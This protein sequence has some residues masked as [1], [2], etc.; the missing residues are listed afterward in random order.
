MNADAMP[1]WER[2][3]RAPTPSFPTW[4]RH[5]PDRLAYVSNESGAYQAYTYDIRSGERRRISDVPI[6]VWDAMPTADGGGVVWFE[7][8]TGDESGR[9]VVA[10]FGG[11]DAETLLPA[12]SPAWQ[13][14]I[15]LGR[16]VIVGAFA[17]RDG[18]AVGAQHPGEGPRRLYRNVE[19]VHIGGSDRAGFN[20]GGL[21]ADERLLCIEHSE[22]G[23]EVRRALRVL[24]AGTGAVVGDQWD[25]EGLGLQAEAWSP[26]AGDPR[27]AIRH[28]RRD[29]ERPAIWDLA[30]NERSDLEIDLPGDVI[31]L[32]WWPDASALLVAHLFEGR[33]ELFR[34]D[35]GDGALARVE[36]PEGTIDDARVRPDGD[37][38]LQVSSGDSAPR[39]L[40]QAGADV[41]T[42]DPRAPTGAPFHSWRFANRS[43]DLVHGFYAAPGG[44]GPFP[45]L[46]YV[47]GGPTGQDAD[48]WDP[49]VQ[50]FVDQGFVVG[51][52]NYRGSTGYGRAWRDFLVGNVG[53]PEEED[54][55]AGLSDLVARGIGDPDRAVIGGWSWGGYVTLLSIGRAPA[56]WRAAVGGVPVGDYAAGYDELSPDLQAYDRYLMGG[57][58]PHDVPELMAE[59]SPIVYAPRVRTPTLVLIGRNDVRC[60]YR[61]AM[62]WVDAVRAHGG[63]VEVYEYDSGHTSYDVDEVVRQMRA[64]LD[65]LAR[66]VVEI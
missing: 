13:A 57:K 25:G 35:L 27:L 17:D 24:D 9:W 44:T 64:I 62:A 51:L 31:P 21:S 7:D 59:R 18:Y 46:M 5:A 56:R 38:W 12:P 47:H 15:A 39:A 26:V 65:F 22:H 11:G 8:V 40:S 2:R 48:R 63:E 58:T 28:E 37:V 14:G 30:R 36:H 50:A 10:P 52:V 6:G 29:R 19:A 53:L 16:R 60:P 43:G 49:F 3:F 1:T 41:L 33:H 42:L 54:V 45:V 61:Q 55:A 23:D 20:L 32:D 34:L 66:R 4:S